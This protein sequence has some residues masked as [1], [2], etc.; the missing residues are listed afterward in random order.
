MNTQDD[1]EGQGS[2]GPATNLRLGQPLPAGRG[3]GGWKPLQPH[4]QV[5]WVRGAGGQTRIVA[6]PPVQSQRCWVENPAS[7]RICSYVGLCVE[8]IRAN[9]GCCA[10][11]NGHG[12]DTHWAERPRPVP[13]PALGPAKRSPAAP[14]GISNEEKM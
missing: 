6:Y 12:A 3:H 10:A 14:V 8:I 2:S 9:T 7:A 4:G 5:P 1:A 13:A 11:R